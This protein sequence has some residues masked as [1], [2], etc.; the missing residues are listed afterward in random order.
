MILWTSYNDRIIF[1]FVER[2]IVFL[3]NQYSALAL[4]SL[5]GR[6][7]MNLSP[8]FILCFSVSTYSCGEYLAVK[9]LNAPLCSPG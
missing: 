2:A 6:L 7:L 8:I 4:A 1:H 9:L 3:S 5:C